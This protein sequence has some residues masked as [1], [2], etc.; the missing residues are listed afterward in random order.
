MKLKHQS[1]LL[2]LQNAKVAEQLLVKVKQQVVVKMVKNQ[3]A[4]AV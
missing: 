1:E 3:E 4:A 2:K